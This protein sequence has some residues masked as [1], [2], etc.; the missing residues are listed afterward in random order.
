MWKF[1][2]LI[3]QKKDGI[4]VKNAACKICVDTILMYVC[5]WN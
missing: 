5:G 2:D 1:F 4:K 3:E